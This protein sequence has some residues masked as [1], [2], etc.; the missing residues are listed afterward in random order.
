MCNI[1]N[2]MDE[3][4]YMDEKLFL[5]ESFVQASLQNKVTENDSVFISTVDKNGIENNIYPTENKKI[6]L[7]IYNIL[8]NKDLVETLSKIVLYK[9]NGIENIRLNE[10]EIN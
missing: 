4:L 6:S 2:D 10:I 3:K 8:T 1:L 9:K 7:L 5:C